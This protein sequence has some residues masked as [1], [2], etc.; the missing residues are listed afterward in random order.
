MHTYILSQIDVFYPVLSGTYT[1]NYS[2]QIKKFS[3]DFEMITANQTWTE[4]LHVCLTPCFSV[5][6]D[7][8]G[9]QDSVHSQQR[10]LCCNTADWKRLVTVLS[11]LYLDKQMAFTD[12][13]KSIKHNTY[14]L[15]AEW[16][17]RTASYGPSFFLPSMAQARSARAMKTRKEKT[18]IH[19]LAY[20][21][22]KWG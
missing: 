4:L 6:F 12:K 20:G 21:P 15:L 1:L 8:S 14:L 5:V 19:N 13:T 16:E 18:R 2:P 11:T 17:V 10:T 3:F 7:L 22:S 9:E